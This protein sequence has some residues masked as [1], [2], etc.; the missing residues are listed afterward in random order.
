ML[1]NLNYYKFEV[2]R[3]IDGDT[4][5]ANIHIFPNIQIQKHIRLLGINCSELH[6]KEDLEVLKAKEALEFTKTWL[7]RQKSYILCGNNFDSFE[8]LLAIV[9]DDS[10]NTLN[11]ALIDK[12]L[13]VNYVRK[14]SI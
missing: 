7:S 4:F 6:S 3:V 11:D 13:A 2:V 8:R 9:Y 1:N 14:I 5:V 12:K 10:N